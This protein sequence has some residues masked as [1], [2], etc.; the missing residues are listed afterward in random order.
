M[1][2]I[3]G[4]V[5]S[6][7]DSGAP[8]CAR[9]M[10]AQVPFGGSGPRFGSLG[11]AA[12]GID[13][14]SS[15]PEDELDRQ[16]LTVEGRH[17]LVADIRIDNRDEL[18]SQLHLA[19]QRRSDAHLFLAAW[20]RWKEHCLAHIVGDFAI[21]VWDQAERRL[22]LAR[23]P[24]GQRPLFYARQGNAIA[25]ASTAAALLAWRELD[26]RFNFPHLAAHL[27]NLGHASD[28]TPFRGIRRVHPGCLISFGERTSEERH[29]QP[30]PDELTLS[31]MEDYVQLYRELLRTAVDARSRRAG[32]RIG[33]QLSSGWDSSAVAAT[34]AMSAQ[35]PIAFTYGPAIGADVPSPRNRFGDETEIASTTAR[36]HGL[37]HVL[38]RPTG[39]ILA[40]LR[41]HAR[42]YQ[43]PTCNIVNMQW[44]SA[45]LAAAKDRGVSVLLNGHMGNLTIHAGGLPVLAEWVRRGDFLEW[46]R[47]ARAAVATGNA[48]WRGVLINS[49]GS[50]LPAWLRR[51]INQAFTEMPSLFERSFVREEWL[52]A[53]R[54]MGEERPA[55]DLYAGRYAER[56]ALI[57]ASD[58]GV[59]RKGA[60]AEAGIDERD[61]T[62]DRRLLDFSFGLPPRHLLHRGI[63]RPLARQAL[64]GLI[65]AAV[66][67]AKKRGYQGAD[68]HLRFTKSDALALL[69][70][71]SASRASELLDFDKMRA[72]IE[73]WPTGGWAEPGTMEIYRSSLP[74]ALATGVFLQEFESLASAASG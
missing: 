27:V 34:A 51:R 68:W 12:F 74:A 11:S 32:G 72:A 59:F 69:E 35:K 28:E 61:P 54:S 25:F 38:V 48:R 70:E 33:V 47:E 55:T 26:H 62:A 29:W 42:L 57:A 64:G 65:P 40:N 41:R 71:V 9:I 73:R 30:P 63:W 36:M 18:S 21:A 44:L 8:L 5:L 49:F 23:D 13:L 56:F 31:S 4:C 17:L 37:D 45:I 1:T 24:T 10:R 67:D 7:G 50:S 6:A 19:P 46:W 43:Q 66:V 2:A 53:A 52:R 20:A 3:A 15:V 60:L 39:S 16:P 22:T 14:H 58:V